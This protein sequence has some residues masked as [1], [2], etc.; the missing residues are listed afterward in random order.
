MVACRAVNARIEQLNEPPR[1]RRQ[2]RMFGF[3][4]HG[5]FFQTLRQGL[6]GRH[7]AAGWLVDDAFDVGK[8]L[9]ERLSGRGVLPMCVGQFGVQFGEPLA[10]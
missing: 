8:D 7:R 5:H 9:T 10:Q 2:R 3:E 4:L 1:A 6:V